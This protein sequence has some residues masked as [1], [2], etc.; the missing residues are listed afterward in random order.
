MNNPA[1]DPEPTGPAGSIHLSNLLTYAALLS[2]CAAAASAIMHQRS[3]AGAFIAVA[4]IADTL[5]GRFARLFRRTR[6]QSAYGV[7]LDSLADAVT[8]GFVP[9]IVLAS[10]STALTRGATLAWWGCAFLYSLAA[11]TRLAYYNLKHGDGP[12]FV[13]VPAPL[14][15]LVISTSLLWSPRP[16]AAAVIMIGCAVAM[17][18]PI[19]VPRP[20]AAGFAAWVGWAM[21]VVVLHVRAL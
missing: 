14:C 15:A 9:V 16:L 3:A 21:L 11:I 6:F 8:S 20:R 2:G 19:R 12:W 10:D 13:G 4:V 18:A 5:D 7:Q 17:I 1:P